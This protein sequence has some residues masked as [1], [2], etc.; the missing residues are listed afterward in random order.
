MRDIKKNDERIQSVITFVI[1]SLDVF[2]EQGEVEGGLWRLT[3]V[4]RKNYEKLVESGFEP[5]P[6]EIIA[7][8]DYLMHVESSEV[9]INGTELV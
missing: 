6:E 4:G 9:S 2:K 7:V 8:M 3:P 5:T 1:G